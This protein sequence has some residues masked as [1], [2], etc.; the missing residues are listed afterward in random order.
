MAEQQTERER[1]EAAMRSTGLGVSDMQVDA[2]VAELEQIIRERM[3]QAWDEGYDHGQSDE[4]LQC[5]EQTPNPYKAKS[6]S[7]ITP[8]GNPVCPKCGRWYGI[9]AQHACPSTPTVQR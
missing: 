8:G 3:A 6:S 7:Q 2:T 9:G 4:Q 1:I 5:D